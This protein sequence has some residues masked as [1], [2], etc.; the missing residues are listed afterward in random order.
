MTSKSHDYLS[1]ELIQGWA[2]Q[3]GA[4]E[5]LWVGSEPETSGHGVISVFGPACWLSLGTTR[6]AELE[7]VKQ[8]PMEISQSYYKLRKCNTCEASRE[9]TLNQTDD[10]GLD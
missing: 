3:E 6:D 1:R 5:G 10:H 7:R 2:V 9:K 4:R 8:T